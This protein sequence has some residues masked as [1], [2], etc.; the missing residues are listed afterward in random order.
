MCPSSPLA[1][2][3]VRNGWVSPN[4]LYNKSHWTKTQIQKSIE[5][6]VRQHALVLP[7]EQQRRVLLTD[8]PEKRRLDFTIVSRK[9]R[10]PDYD[11][12]VAGLKLLIDAMKRRR[13]RR[14]AIGRDKGGRKKYKMELRQD[15]T[16]FVWDDDPEWIEFGE[17]KWERDTQVWPEGTRFVHVEI[18]PATSG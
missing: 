14:T 7:I 6:E 16:G 13:L 18:Y 1:T 2:L 17:V 12:L 8:T 3:L 15:G 5:Q 4:V 11:N 10:H 9:G